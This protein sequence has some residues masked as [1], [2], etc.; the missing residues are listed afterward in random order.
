MARAIL[1]VG[2]ARDDGE[3]AADRHRHHLLRVGVD[4]DWSADPAIPLEALAS[5]P[6][7]RP[8]PFQLGKAFIG[9]GSVRVLYGGGL[10]LRHPGIIGIRLRRHVL[11]VPSRN[12]DHL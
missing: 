11:S 4:H 12:P 10:N 5:Q 7:A 3:W 8:W 2:V 1:P 6:L 9:S